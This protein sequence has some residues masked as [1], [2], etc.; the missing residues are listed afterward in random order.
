[1]K[2]EL[3]TIVVAIAFLLGGAGMSVVY[4]QKVESQSFGVTA[5]LANQLSITKQSDVD[6]GGIFIPVTASATATMDKAG[7]VTI[8]NGTTTLYSTELQRAGSFYITADKAATYTLQYPNVVELTLP[9]GD[10]KL[11]YTPKLFNKAGDVIPSSTST[12]YQVGEEQYKLYSIGG[13]LVIP[14]TA[15]SGIHTGTFDLTVTWQ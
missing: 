12:E 10:S 1:M 6:F 14:N 2:K 9:S 11:N 13:D 5:R 15:L 4:A 3:M 8:S 7:T